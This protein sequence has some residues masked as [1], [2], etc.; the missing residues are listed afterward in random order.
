MTPISAA[1][2][3]DRAEELKASNA[4]CTQLPFARATPQAAKILGK[5]AWAF[6]VVGL[7][8]AV[9]YV[10]AHRLGLPPWPAAALSVTATLIVTGALHEDGL[11]DA[12]DGFGGGGSR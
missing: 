10:L 5:A 7:V 2:F 1:W 12:A 6:P 9:V 4:F 3:E 11:A 8:V